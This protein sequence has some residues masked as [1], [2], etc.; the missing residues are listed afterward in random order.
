MCLFD[1]CLLERSMKDPR[2]DRAVGVGKKIVAA[3][4]HSWKRQR[5]LQ[6]AQKLGSPRNQTHN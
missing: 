3:F 5:A 2:T 6:N 1:M 4:G